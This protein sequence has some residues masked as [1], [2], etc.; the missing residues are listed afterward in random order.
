MESEA[1]WDNWLI[2]VRHTAELGIGY[3]IPKRV[4]HS[5]HDAQLARLIEV[6][7]VARRKRDREN[8]AERVVAQRG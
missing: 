7:N 6:R 8:G 2:E 3:A 5:D 4:Q 1:V